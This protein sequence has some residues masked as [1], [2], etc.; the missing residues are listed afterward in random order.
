[1]FCEFPIEPGEPAEFGGVAGWFAVRVAPPSPQLVVVAI[2]AEHP[3]PPEDL[4][5][6]PLGIIR[7]LLPIQIALLGL[8]LLLI[9]GPGVAVIAPEPLE[10]RG[11]DLIGGF[12]APR[13]SPP[14]V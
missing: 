3:F 7:R 12:L 2:L 14:Q 6:A 4:K 13:V 8:A 10:C 9:P 1:M 11:F 5:P